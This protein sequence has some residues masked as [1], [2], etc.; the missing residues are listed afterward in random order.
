MGCYT[1]PPGSLRGRGRRLPVGRPVLGLPV[2]RP[3]LVVLAPAFKRA[4]QLTASDWDREEAR[5]V[6][7]LDAQKD[8]PFAAGP[9][10]C[11]GLA[12]LLRCGHAL[13]SDIEN[14]VTV[15]EALRRRR[16]IRIDLCHDD[17]FGPRACHLAGWS[18]REAELRHIGAV[19]VL[20]IAGRGPGFALLAR[21]FAER[22]VDR[23]LTTLANDAELHVGAGRQARNP[24]GELACVLDL[25]AIDAGDHVARLD[26][27]LHCRTI[28]LGLSH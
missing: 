6:A 13:P 19:A 4:R 16:T 8:C 10:I 20:T 12:H 26:A 21:E 9:R 28:R 17:T 11:E 7:R 1:H 18:E 2:G 22:N 24:L 23:L 5:V 14:D 15:L 3:V 25:L 27:G